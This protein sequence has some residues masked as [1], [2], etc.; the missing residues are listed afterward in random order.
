MAIKLTVVD[1][2]N[3]L[4]EDFATTMHRYV[5]RLKRH[6]VDDPLTK[7][8]RKAPI[9]AKR[10]RAMYDGAAPYATV[11]DLACVMWTYEDLMGFHAA[12]K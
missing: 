5:I 3:E 7:L 8:A 12:K 9:P 11:Q 10:V 1:S 4:C 2:V 6:G